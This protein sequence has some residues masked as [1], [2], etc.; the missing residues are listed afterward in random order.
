[1]LCI[2]AVLGGPACTASVEPT[3]E[4]EITQ[5]VT[6]P[7]KV[8]GHCDD[9]VGSEA[10]TLDTSG[11]SY[12]NV[13]AKVSLTFT[14]YT[15]Q[16]KDDSLATVKVECNGKTLDLTQSNENTPRVWENQE[17]DDAI[18]MFAARS[19]QCP[20]PKMSDNKHVG[21]LPSCLPDSD[22][23]PSGSD[24]PASNSGAPGSNGIQTSPLFE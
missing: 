13:Q 17:G 23:S 19:H 16:K 1:M 2:C 7:R 22:T 9:K 5:K 4:S 14:S 15:D 12:E 11:T 24:T 6:A 21:K 20:I 10:Y 3:Q 8:N 18:V